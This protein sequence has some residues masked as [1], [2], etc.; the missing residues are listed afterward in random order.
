MKV[1]L[2]SQIAVVD[3]KYTYSLANALKRCGNEVELVIDDKKDNKYCECKC[4]NKF[5]TS[6]KDISKGKKLLN[7]VGTYRFIVKKAISEHFDIVHV[8]WFQFSPVDYYF[9]K[10]L[11][12]YG[13]KLVVSVHDILPFNEKK[14]DLF[15]HR[16]IYGLCNQIIVQAETNV[17]RF[18]VLFPED[19]NKV[20]Y[21]PH[22]HFLDFADKHGIEES[23]KHLNIPRDKTVLLF[24]GQIKTVKGVGVLLEAFGRLSQKRD[25]LYLVIAGSVWK[26]DFKP[27]EEI[28]N[29]YKLT[30]DQLKTDIR[31][32][33]D[34]EVGF[35]YSSCDIAVLP[36]L[37]VYQSGVI[38]LAY[39]YGKPA[40]A[41]SIAPFMEIVEDGITGFLCKPG[42]AQNLAKTIELAVEKK[43]KFV[44]FGENGRQ[45]INEKYSWQNIG[46]K[47]TELYQRD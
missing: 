18:D 38:Q 21:I 4:I 9:L 2:L 28:I 29:H 22:G 30:G 46:K 40:I 43:E 12:K 41:T 8:Q 13:V 7:Y 25:D 33:P 27:Y 14:Y 44:M 45:K 11:K 34:D 17:K 47:I 3:Y 35:Y 5:L 23:R 42:D 20:T 10:K 36:Y 26:D 32:I 16:K 6:R 19:S 15:F 37:D 24:F 39:A 31:F 1:L